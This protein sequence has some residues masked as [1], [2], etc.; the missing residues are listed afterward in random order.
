VYQ[1]DTDD[2]ACRTCSKL[3]CEICRKEQTRSSF[4][5]SQLKHQLNA[6]QNCVVRCTQC[7]VCSICSHSKQAYY[8]EDKQSGCKTCSDLKIELQCFICKISKVKANFSEKVR[9]N[10]SK[11]QSAAICLECAK[12]GCSS[13]DTNNYQC[14]HGC[15]VG[16]QL[17]SSQQL[18]H[19]KRRGDLLT[20]A[21]CLKREADIF[22]KLRVKG[23]WKCSC[24]RQ[25]GHEER[26][27]L[28]P[29]VSGKRRCPGKNQGATQLDWKFIQGPMKRR[30][31]HA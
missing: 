1:F 21:R 3:Q 25:A 9:R 10:V 8:F 29:S 11:H 24:H 22:K 30:K 19:H 16:H 18:D 15:I 7:H 26:C 14:S 27:S 31:T 28:H 13:R 2:R 20:C 17:M 12:Q 5:K 4:P 6:N 23:S